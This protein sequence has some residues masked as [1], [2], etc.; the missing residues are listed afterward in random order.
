MAAASTPG[1]SQYADKN[2]LGTNPLTDGVF[3]TI[4][5]AGDATIGGTLTVPTIDVA[6]VTVANAT[7]T[8][9][10][11]TNNLVATG[12]TS[13]ANTDVDGTLTATSVIG[14]NGEFGDLFCNYLQVLANVYIS[15]N[16]EIDGK[17]ALYFVRH[18]QRPSRCHSPSPMHAWVTWSW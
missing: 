16:L 2:T 7:I 18:H 13:L 15:G 3:D 9:T 1:T 10:A 17:R 12:S 8:N 6:N 4:T 5:V 11:T 14:T